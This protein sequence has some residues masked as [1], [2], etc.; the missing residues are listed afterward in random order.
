MASAPSTMALATTTVTAESNASITSGRYGIEAFTNGT[1]NVAVSTST[2]DIIN[3]GSV[4]ILAGNFA[5]AVPQAA[6]STITVTARGTI[7]SGSI[8]T[9]GGNVADGILAG[10]LGGPTLRQT[11][12]IRTCSAT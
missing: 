5:S 7:N 11:C 6:H 4:G 10:Y 8:L 3:S 9:A 12:Q 1:G 2:G